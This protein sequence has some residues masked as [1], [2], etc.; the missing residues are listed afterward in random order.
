MND[1]CK[2]VKS[3]TSFLNQTEV[4]RLTK[5]NPKHIRGYKFVYNTPT[6]KLTPQQVADIVDLIILRT[7]KLHDGG[8]DHD[9]IKRSLK[10]EIKWLSV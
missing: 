7:R 8:A 9:Q 4:A 10:L 6:Q 2:H 1:I 3:S 5:E